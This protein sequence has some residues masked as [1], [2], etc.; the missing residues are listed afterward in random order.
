MVTMHKTFFF[1][2]AALFAAFCNTAI[3][4][5]LVNIQPTQ[6]AGNTL[7]NLS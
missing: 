7:D 1:A 2:A 3:A 6:L 4:V 5:D